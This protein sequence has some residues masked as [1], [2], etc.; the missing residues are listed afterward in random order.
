MLAR[1]Q[2]EVNHTGGLALDRNRQLL[3]ELLDRINI[4][5]A[6]RRRAVQQA[7]SDALP[8]TWR[9]RAQDFWAAAT[10]PGDWPGQARLSELAERGREC[11]AIARA[12]EAHAVLLAEGDPWSTYE[13]QRDQFLAE[14]AQGWQAD[15]ASLITGNRPPEV[16]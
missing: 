5:E 8:E 1:L 6:V 9:R 13:A 3:R 7:I 4:A 14:F 2:P 16:G 15:L 10:Q 11:L 12:C